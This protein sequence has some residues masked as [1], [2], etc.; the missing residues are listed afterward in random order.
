MRPRNSLVLVLTLTMASQAFALELV[1]GGKAVARIVV[2]ADAPRVERFAA[3]ELQ[4]AIVAMSGAKLPIASDL[5]GEAAAWVLVGEGAARLAGDDVVTAAQLAEVRDDGYAMATVE[6]GQRPYLVLLAQQPRG[7]LFAVYNLLETAFSCGFFT[8]G[9]RYPKRRDLAVYGLSIVGNPTFP[10]RACWVPARFYGPKRF[11]PALW[12][13]K[14]WRRFLLWM[15]KK[16]MN[17]L[18]VELSGESRAWGEAFEQA[19]PEARRLKR[20]TLAPPE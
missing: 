19:F 13:A 17:C 2:A 1:R 8:D 15:A 11:R 12:D 5:S 6:T 7:T 18:A 3:S 4:S 10:L 20:E 14:D 9:D 16:K